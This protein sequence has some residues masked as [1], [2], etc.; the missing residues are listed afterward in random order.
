MLHKQNILKR[1]SMKLTVLIIA[2]LII[3]GCME[4]P[5]PVRKIEVAQVHESTFVQKLKLLSEQRKID[6]TKELR[7]Q[8]EQGDPEALI[9]LAS[10]YR[11]GVGVQKDIKEAKILE[12]NAAEAYLSAAL[13]GDVHAQLRLAQG[14][15]NG[16]SLPKDDDE[17][18]RWYKKAL[19]SLSS[20]PDQGDGEAQ[21]VLSNLY[22]YGELIY[23]GVFPQDYREAMKWL[24]KAAEKGY[25]KA[26]GLVGDYYRT[27]LGHYYDSPN[28]VM[29]NNAKA[30]KWYTLAAE[31]GYH[32]ALLNLGNMYADGRGVTKDCNK[33]IT[34]Y[35]RDAELGYSAGPSNLASMYQTGKCVA[36][37]IQKAYMWTL[38]SGVQGL[39]DAFSWCG[40]YTKEMTPEQINEAENMTREWLVKHGR[41]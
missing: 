7:L 4:S 12:R 16:S 22:N 39:S 19:T 2:S 33:A 27:G 1:L 24:E 34:L 6:K 21:Y 15:Y 5:A 25:V 10:K 14:Y 26:Q 28:F 32:G 8:A 36:K 30:V 18:M 29:R 31:N 40:I 20:N 17:A 11:L 35:T 37:D 23:G 13:Q 9:A 41:L 3:T 38:I